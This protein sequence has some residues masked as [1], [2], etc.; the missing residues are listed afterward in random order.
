MANSLRSRLGKPDCPFPS[1]DQRERISWLNEGNP[2]NVPQ[3]WCR[4]MYNQ[5]MSTLASPG[6]ERRVILKVSGETYERLLAEPLLLRP[7]NRLQLQA[8]L[9]SE[10][11]WLPLPGKWHKTI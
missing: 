8:L 4:G 2:H 3:R 11:Q 6:V 5:G 9:F 1:R 7:P 10:N